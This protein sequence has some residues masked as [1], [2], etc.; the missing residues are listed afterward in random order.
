MRASVVRAIALAPFAGM[1]LQ[2]T[3][4]VAEPPTATSPVTPVE[5]EVHGSA[6]S[7][8]EAPLDRGVAGTT[9][10][11]GELER[12]GLTAA[13]VLRTQVGATITE[14]GGLGAASTASIRG[15]TAAETPVY[16]G[17]VRINDDVGGAADLSTLPLW[18]IDRVELYRGN[19]P[20][21][22][23]RFG[24]GGAI[25]FQ[26]LRP[27]TTRG[28]VGTSAGSYGYQGGYAYGSVATPERGVLVGANLS[29]AKNDYAFTDN[30]GEP[31]RWHNADATLADVWI[32]GRSDVGSGSVELTLN[33]FRREQGAVNSAVVQTHQARQELERTL[34]A[35]T[36]RAPLG[37]HSLLELRTSTL[38]ARS[39][40]D[41]PLREIL[42]STA[43]PGTKLVQRGERVEQEAAVRFEPSRTLRARIAVQASSERLRRFENAQLPELEPTLDA[44]R[45][46]GR[47]A[48]SAETDVTRWLALRALLALE[49]HATTTGMRAAG[50]DSLEP[51]GRLGGT[52]H[53]GELGG[54]VALGRYTRPPTLGELYGT[55]LVTQGNR[56]LESE[57]GV[58]L[59]VGARFAHA[60]PGESAPLYAAVSG[61]ARH[62]TELIAFVHTAQGYVR[63][64][65]V[66]TADA[67]GLELEAGAGFARYFTADL[68]LTL[69][70]FRGQLPAPL[71]NDILPYHSRLIAAPRITARSP[72]LGQRWVNR[73]TLGATL[74]YQSNRYG[75][76]SGQ[77]VIPEQASLDVDAALLL[78][79][80][81]LWLKARVMDVLDADRWDVVGFPLP[82]RSVYVSLEGRF[83]EH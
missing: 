11:R 41:D 27:R 16:L 68:A 45:I 4:A 25:L 15:A 40:L 8:A 59:D 14:T 2:A 75:D 33:H 60:L 19:A 83:G 55:S 52:W 67:L 57:S 32:L 26:P 3:P 51:V 43:S 24:I 6:P 17:G 30:T 46:T 20:F 9:V 42:P 28:A 80:H 61:Y 63:P 21:D 66:D 70:D 12:P 69:L 38:L 74:V 81:R 79:E 7:P 72:D 35:I 31:D 49:C 29:G 73:G 54:F 36:G 37:N 76:F 58:T 64:E 1:A 13:E 82:R 48:G 71:V 62:A 77:G 34:G 50:C 10:R 56:A 18:L 53:A 5:V 23:D 47:V 44:E 22:L 78:L 65:N 39:T